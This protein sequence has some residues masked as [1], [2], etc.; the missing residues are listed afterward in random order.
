MQRKVFTYI[1]EFIVKDSEQTA[2][3]KA[4]GP[5]GDWVRLFRKSQGYLGTELHQ[6]QSNPLRYLTL[7]YWRSKE[8][9]DA[10]RLQFAHE[11]QQ[12][13]ARCEKFAVQEKFLGDYDGFTSR[14][15]L[16][17]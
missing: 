6:D 7:D 3:E 4:Y 9:R 16:A 5:E 1:W 11:F 13:D 2:F 17:E 10:F 12:L 15:P 14:A 8:D